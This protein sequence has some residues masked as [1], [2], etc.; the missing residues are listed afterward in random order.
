MPFTYSFDYFFF[1]TIIISESNK[2]KNLC[3]P[4]LEGVGGVVLSGGRVPVLVEAV[5]LR[6]VDDPVVVVILAV[7]EVAESRLKVAAGV[8][9][10]ADVINGDVARVVGSDDALECNLNKTREFIQQKRKVKYFIRT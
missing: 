2:K 10:D 8:G 5:G 6:G 9:L 3:T 1:S 7:L 4:T